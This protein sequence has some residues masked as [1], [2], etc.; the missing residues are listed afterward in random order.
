[1]DEIAEIYKTAG[2]VII[3]LK[4]NSKM[5]AV[6]WLKLTSENNDSLIYDGNNIGIKCGQVSKITVIDV[7]Y[8]SSGLLT[9][10]EMYDKHGQPEFDTCTCNTAGGGLHFYFAYDQ[11][12]PTSVN[13][14]QGIDIRNDGSYVVAPPSRVDGHEYVWADNK[15]PFS[16]SVAPI[17]SWFKELI[18]EE[19]KKKNSVSFQDMVRITPF[20]SVIDPNQQSRSEH[21][22]A[23]IKYIPRLSAE[24]ASKYSSWI[25]V[26]LLARGF[27]TPS[28]DAA[29]LNA[30][31]EFSK[32]CPAKFKGEKDVEKYYFGGKVYIGTNS[33]Q[34][35]IK[36]LYWMTNKDL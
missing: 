6:S 34:M 12:I 15:S 31:I 7:D 28:T 30:C 33:K 2:N 18:L 11:E 9:L 22:E 29:L 17:P 36:T 26:I 10:Q 27:S 5:P 35:S 19:K 16:R 4:K 24:R 23:L 32:K 1:M 3:P 13:I 14:F 21:Y 25:Q 8:K 20:P